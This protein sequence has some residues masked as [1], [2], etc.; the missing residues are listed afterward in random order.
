MSLCGL[1]KKN[2]NIPSNYLTCLLLK[3]YVTK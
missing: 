3:E 2:Q 1:S